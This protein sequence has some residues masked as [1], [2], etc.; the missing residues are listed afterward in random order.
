MKIQLV[1][2]SLLISGSLFAKDRFS[3]DHFFKKLQDSANV[4]ADASPEVKSSIDT[5]AQTLTS[6]TQKA[7]QGGLAALPQANAQME[8]AQKQLNQTL[9][10]TLGSLDQ[11][12][13]EDIHSQIS[14][15]LRE[16][17]LNSSTGQM[18]KDL[19]VQGDQL[20]KVTPL[21]KSQMEKIS[22]MFSTA[23]ASGGIAGLQD[24]QS[25]LEGLQTDF[26][27]QISSVLTKDQFQ[28]MQ[29]ERNKLISQFQTL[30]ED[31]DVARI[32]SQLGDLGE[33]KDEIEGILKDGFSQK[34]DILKNSKDQ[35]KNQARGTLDQ[36]ADVDGQ[37]QGKVKGILGDKAGDTVG[38]YQKKG[39]ASLRD[40]L[41]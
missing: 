28:K 29:S 35:L 21:V 24:I 20:K 1:L 31:N 30:L 16:E 33:H 8:S 9:G 14:D 25:N 38:E 6:I 32:V 40:R 34:A 3:T 39:L 37:V 10:D 27:K 12:E 11:K 7:Q 15:E 41:K 22:D 18:I 4:P 36:I 2:V 19:N 17:I 13:L 26:D 5:H 23:W